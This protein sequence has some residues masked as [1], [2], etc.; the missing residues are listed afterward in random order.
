MRTDIEI[1]EDNREHAI[2]GITALDS[3]GN[4]LKTIKDIFFDKQKA[5]NFVELCN[6][7]KLELI[8]LQ[9]A[10]EDVLV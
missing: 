4:V 8:H 9:D 5:E 7:E 3:S 6:K 2:Y 10:A 1:D